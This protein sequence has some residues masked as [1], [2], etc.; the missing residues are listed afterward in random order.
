MRAARFS[1]LLVSAWVLVLVWACG[2]PPQETRAR[3]VPPAEKRTDEAVAWRPVA[4]PA[5]EVFALATE[6]VDAQGLTRRHSD[7]GIGLIKAR[8]PGGHPFTV[9]VRATAG[10]STLGVSCTDTAAVSGV[11]PLLITS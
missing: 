11:L 7:D 3:F 2:R 9:L 4:A 1:A 8:T 10:G 5:A 6:L